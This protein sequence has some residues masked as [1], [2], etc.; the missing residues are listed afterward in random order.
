MF[1]KFIYYIYIM[2]KILF[3]I[4]FFLLSFQISFAE[5]SSEKL[6]SLSNDLTLVNLENQHLM[7]RIIELEKKINYNS[8]ESTNSRLTNLETDNAKLEI[9]NII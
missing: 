9:N 2:K 7:G 5:N 1:L 3:I 4:L 8:F 6:N